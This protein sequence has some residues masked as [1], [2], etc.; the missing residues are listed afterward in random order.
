MS[1]VDI[2]HKKRTGSYYTPELVAQTLVRWSVLQDSDRLLDPSCGD[3]RFLAYHRRSVGVENDHGAYASAVQNAPWS[4]V[5]EADFFEWASETTER[6]ECAAGNPPFVRYQRFSGKVREHAQALCRL[7]NVEI[8]GLAS[9]WA[10]FLVVTA[11]LLKPGG[12]MSFVVPAEIG[13]APYARPVLQYLMNNFRVVRL[14]ATRQKLF[15]DLSEDCWLL[16]AAEF[17]GR[18]QSLGFTSSDG[19]HATAKPPRA[20]ISISRD[21]LERWNW[22]VRPFLLRSDIREFYLHASEENSAQR[23]GDIAKVGIGYVTGAN[24]FFHLRPSEAKYLRI[25][26]EFLRP[27]VRSGRALNG[28]AIDR[29]TVNVWRARDDKMLLL[30]LTRDQPV[31]GSVMRYLES[32]AAREVKSAYKCRMR[33]PW[34]AVPDVVVPDAFLTYMSGK[35]P[36]LVANDAACVCSNAVHGVRMKNGATLRQLLERWH[37]PFTAL[38]CELEG[39]PLG[40]GLLKLEPREANRILLRRKTAEGEQELIYRG[41]EVLRAWRHCA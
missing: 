25:P 26:P 32:S 41:V 33:D 17:G 40:G 39:H 4:L 1:T 21:E 15:P 31:P 30:A 29:E 24:E 13:H 9:S 14:T 19:F 38:S 18:A 36:S 28:L 34:Y 3:G 8:T 35:G 10:P 11:S 22:R 12:R 37:N 16:H 7:S 2:H 27:S 23:L 6:F 5:H 20:S